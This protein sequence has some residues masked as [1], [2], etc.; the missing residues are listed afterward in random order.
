MM[1]RLIAGLSPTLVL[2]IGGIIGTLFT[3]F[4]GSAYDRLIDDP[5]VRKE[6]LIGFV[7]KAELE[8]EKARAQEAQR[9]RDLARKA[10]AEYA[11]ILAKVR[12]QE[13][14]AKADLEQRIADYESRLK[15]AG[16]SC[17]LDQS[18]IDWLRK[19]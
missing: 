18:D 11:D 5:N 12:E 1:L 2:A 6:A 10:A 4:I 13:S 7:A 8:A 15:D 19:P 16:R 9:Q 3:G 14:E 17:I